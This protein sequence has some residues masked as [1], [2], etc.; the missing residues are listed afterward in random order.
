MK[1]EMEIYFNR[2]RDDLAVIEDW[3]I[4]GKVKRINFT[5]SEHWDE[6]N[7]LP[8]VDYSV[9][10][11]E[12]EIIGDLNFDTFEDAMKDIAKRLQEKK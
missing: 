5:V 8:V 10:D 12:G 4:N 7:N 11:E 3:I 1:R 2:L 9:E 6:D